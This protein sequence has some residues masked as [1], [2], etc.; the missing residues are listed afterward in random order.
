MMVGRPADQPAIIE[1]QIGACAGHG[2]HSLWW[3]AIGFISVPL[4]FAPICF[5]YDD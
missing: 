4:S 5:S 1:I 2:S 3:C